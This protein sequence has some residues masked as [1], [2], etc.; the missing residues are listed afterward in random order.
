MALPRGYLPESVSIEEVVVADLYFDL[1]FNNALI[2]GAKQSLRVECI[3]DET[4]ELLNIDI[5]N[6]PADASAR[7]SDGRGQFFSA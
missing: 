6:L 2:H 4:A 3:F 5:H 1:T 7:D